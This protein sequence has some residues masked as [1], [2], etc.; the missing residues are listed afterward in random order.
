MP[1][2]VRRA[3]VKNHNP[4]PLIGLEAVNIARAGSISARYK[5]KG[6]AYQ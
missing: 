6:I 4:L 1:F 3:V 5:P 2:S